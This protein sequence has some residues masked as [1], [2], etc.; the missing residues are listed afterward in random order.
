MAMI[1]NPFTPVTPPPENQSF[2]QKPVPLQPALNPPL[3]PSLHRTGQGLDLPVPAPAIS[4][5][6]YTTTQLQRPSQPQIRA[7]KRER[8][9]PN[10]ARIHSAMQPPPPPTPP[11][12]TTSASQKPQVHAE[13]QP[14]SQPQPQPQLEAQDQ[15]TSH[16]TI[17]PKD[18]ATVAR[19][20]SF[21]QQRCHAIANYQQQ[22]CQAW[23]N[24]YRQKCQE[25][26]QAAMLV[27]AWYVRDRIRRRRRRRK[28]TFRRGLRE[29]R[30]RPRPASRREAVRK[31]VMQ[32]PRETLPADAVAMDT[33]ADK[34]EKEF[35][36][37]VEAPPDRDAKL[38]EVADGLIKSQYRGV[39]VPLM[40][41]LSF[42]ESESE[43]ESEVD[44]GRGC[45][46]CNGGRSSEMEVAGDLPEQECDEDEGEGEGEG[47]GEEE[48]YYDY[49]EEELY[50]DEDMEDLDEEE[51]GSEVVQ[52]AGTGKTSEDTEA[53]LPLL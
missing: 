2:P 38:F 31:W 28:D 4:G 6:Q 21:Y 10:L 19:I 46:R 17:D 27:V 43:S 53:V 48:E 52:G 12:P 18:I 24:A 25:T 32:V 39:E 20:A 29:R 14:Q 50:D 26:M 30:A 41:V 7:Q 16:A 44:G 22:R 9:G 49:D 45:L 8:Q 34:E 35:N 1:M 15:E 11:L 47:E 3:P 23:A 33:V 40:G 13:T 5:A 37:D 36:L 42:E 51:L